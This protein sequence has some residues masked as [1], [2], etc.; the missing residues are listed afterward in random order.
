[1]K[2]KTLTGATL[3]ASLLFASAAYADITIGLVAPLTGP[4]AA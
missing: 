4:V 2:L 3:A 1:M